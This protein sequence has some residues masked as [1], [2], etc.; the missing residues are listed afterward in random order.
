M[1]TTGDPASVV[2][3]AGSRDRFTDDRAP[4]TVVGSRGPSGA[5]RL[6]VDTEGLIG[7]DNGALRLRPLVQPGWGR[8]GIAYGPFERVPGLALC[9]HVLNGHNASQTFYFPERRLQR[10][11]RMLS[12]LRHRR[13]TR[14]HH[15]ENLAVGFLPSPDATDPIRRG[16]SLVMHA[17]TEDNGELWT[18][19]GGSAARIV[20][21]VQNLPFLFVVCLRAEGA[22]YYTSSLPGAT[23]AAPYPDLRPVGIDGTTMAGPL[24]AAVQQRI[25]GEVGYRV[26]SRVYGVDVAVVDEWAGPF[27]TAHAADRFT[28]A[29]PLDGRSP[30]VGSSWRADPGLSV[31]GG[32]LRA[33]SAS[34]ATAMPATATLATPDPSGL[35]RV[36]VVAGKRPGRVSLRWRLQDGGAHLAVELD[37]NG[38]EV[39]WQPADGR[40]RVLLSDPGCRLRARARHTVQVLDDGRSVA[41]HLDGRLVGERWTSVGDLPDGGGAGLGLEGDVAVEVVEAHPRL[42]PLPPALDCGPPWQ[43]AP[44]ALEFDERFDAVATDLNGTTTPSGGRRWHRVEGEGTIE[45][46]GDHA[47]VDAD[48]ERPNPGRTIFTVPWDDPAYADVELDMTIPGTRRGETHNGRC[49][50]VFWQDPDNY[51]VV[52]FFVDDVFDGASISTFY[53]LGGYEQMYD[54][55]WTLVPGVTWGERCRLRAAFDGERFLALTNDEPCLVR[56]LRDVY[57]DTPPLRIEQVGIIVNREWGDDTG[58]VLHGFRAGR[59]ATAP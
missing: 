2:S 36:V 43:P 19:I 4:G 17:A 44:S 47:R 16:H 54:A 40:E 23:G 15:Y 45:L 20:R 34:G 26:D 55:V 53:H 35:L 25:L 18:A 50:I 58:T 31:A 51:L 10:W 48:L 22:A 21:G 24:V 38:C 46:L 29:G 41:V 12:D 3:G 39:R 8:E 28:V 7:I 49:G 30:V 1:T 5:T 52:N 32:A 14:Q 13:P 59:R 37:G 33:E 56:A 42:I 6:G 57:P 9:A 27:G 11:R